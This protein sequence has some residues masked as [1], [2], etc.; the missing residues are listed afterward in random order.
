MKRAACYLAPPLICLAVFWRVPFLWFRTDDF[1][2]LTLHQRVHDLASLGRAL[3][4]PEAQGTV[5][6]LSDRLYFLILSSLFGDWA[7]PFR[8]CSLAT[9]FG[10]LTLASAIG[11]RLTG[12]RLAGMAAAILW[13]TSYVLVVPLAWAAA[14][15]QLLCAFLLLAALYAR[16]RWLD[17]GARK[18]LAAEWAAYL[19]GFGA[20]EITVMYPAAALLYTWCVARRKDST[21][22]ALFVPAAIFAGAHFLFIPRPASVAYQV[23]AD[24]RVF[25]TALEYV[26][27]ALAPEGFPIRKILVAALAGFFFWRLWRRDWAVLFGAGWFV[28]F[29]APVLPLPNHISIYYLTIPLAGLAWFLA[30]GLALAW[31]TN[32]MAGAASTMVAVLFVAGSLPT[33]N[34]DT[35][36][37]LEHTSRMR[38]LVR[39]AEEMADRH[40]VTALILKDVDNELFQTGLQDYPF[41]LAGID[42]VYLAPGSEMG[43]VARED[44]GGVSVFRISMEDCLGL[45]ESGRARVLEVSAGGPLDVTAPYDAALRAEFAATHRGFVDV[46]D[47]RYASDLGAGW[48]EPERG[49]RWMGKSAS[50][51]LAGPA[52]PSERLYVTG[53]GGALVTLRFRANG[54]DLGSFAVRRMNQPFAVDFSLPAALVGRHGMEVSIESSGT[55]RPPGDPR[56]VGIIFGTFA[57]R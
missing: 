1:A 27:L 47:A 37:W 20:L 55:F 14:Y 56:D 41:K 57:V 49:F 3:F 36:W 8:L 24:A 6:V 29:L 30:S 31:R 43:I 38:L 21:V 10:A 15:N 5:R 28:L 33:I 48:Y 11:F 52:S 17:T 13:T 44:L 54:L 35:T 32:R 12:S 19:L 16:T 39:G 9:W 53:Y 18:W 23:T 51:E 42:Q 26:R 7:A 45:L 34:A 2:W 50:V 25:S 22:F 40:P 46:G 4:H